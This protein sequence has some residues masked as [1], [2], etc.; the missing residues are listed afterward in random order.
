[1]LATFLKKRLWHRYF[2]LNF[3]KL[4]RIPFF[5]ERLWWLLLNINWHHLRIFLFFTWYQGITKKNFHWEKL[6]RSKSLGTTTKWIS[7]QSLK[8]LYTLAGSYMFKLKKRD[9][10]PVLK[11]VKNKKVKNKKDNT[12]SQGCY[13]CIFSAP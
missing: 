3:A 7:N 6:S 11:Y 2:S 12:T 9:T 1:M 5:I 4:L 13:K 8:F 10:R